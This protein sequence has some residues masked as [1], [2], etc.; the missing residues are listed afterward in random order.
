MIITLLP[1]KLR[2]KSQK[3]NYLFFL[4]DKLRINSSILYIFA[5]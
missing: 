4:F 3:A 1:A 2:I 5:L